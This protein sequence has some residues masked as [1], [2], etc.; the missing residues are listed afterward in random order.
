MVRINNKVYQ[1][2]NEFTNSLGINRY[3]YVYVIE[4][5]MGYF[6]IE[7]GAKGFS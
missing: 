5:K 1:L 2:N 3:V 4:G 7:T 6:L